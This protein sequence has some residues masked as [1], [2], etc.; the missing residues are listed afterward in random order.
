[1]PIGL[2][3]FLN[4]FQGTW[5]FPREK[6]TINFR[7]LRHPV[8]CVKKVERT[9]PFGFANEFGRTTTVDANLN[10]IA[11]YF[12]GLFDQSKYLLRLAI[13]NDH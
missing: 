9:F 11:L 12:S 8:E 13:G 2:E 1:M 4:Q 10:K 3:V 7:H 6:G 5:K